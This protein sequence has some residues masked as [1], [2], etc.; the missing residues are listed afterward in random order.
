MEAPE[1]IFLPVVDEEGKRLLSTIWW[2][3]D[4]RTQNEKFVIDVIP[5]IRKDIH[6]ETIQTAEDHA[7]FA[8]REKMREELLEWAEGQYERLM[9][10]FRREVFGL[11]ERN[12]ADAYKEFIEKIKSL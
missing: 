7:M 8:G 4:N 2:P 9:N 5:Y 11:A 6:D 12:M 1:K 10:G 3:E